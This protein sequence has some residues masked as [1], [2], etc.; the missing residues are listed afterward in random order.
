MWISPICTFWDLGT[1]LGKLFKAKMSYWTSLEARTSPRKRREQ[2]ACQ[3]RYLQVRS[4]GDRSKDSVF[5]FSVFA[6]IIHLGPGGGHSLLT[7]EVPWAPWRCYSFTRCY[8][9]P[10]I[11]FCYC[12]IPESHGCW[13]WLLKQIAR[14]RVK[15][16]LAQTTGVPSQPWTWVSPQGRLQSLPQ[17]EKG[18]LSLLP[19]PSLLP[20]TSMASLLP[21]TPHTCF[22][23]ATCPGQSGPCSRQVS[24]TVSRTPVW[25]ISV[26][27][28][29]KREEL[30]LP[31]HL[32]VRSGPPLPW[33]GGH[34]VVPSVAAWH[35]PYFPSSIFQHP[36]S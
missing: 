28:F 8:E 17:P 18:L 31:G 36:S 13:K 19:L 14:N 3:D 33:T 27:L 29:K 16:G 15:A 10:G 21:A 12:R 25:R 23:R 7:P 5:S 32:G 22:R 4:A 2:G 1:K 11:C 24:I 30:P 34:S 26:L 20:G 6:Q 9:P 35:F